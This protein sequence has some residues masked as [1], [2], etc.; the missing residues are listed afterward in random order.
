MPSCQLA[1]W[2][3]ITLMPSSEA[4]TAVWIALLDFHLGVAVAD[5]LAL[6]TLA[7]PY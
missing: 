5:G 7:R 3:G 4:S 1:R 6:A 2:L